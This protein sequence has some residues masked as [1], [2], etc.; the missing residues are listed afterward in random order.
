MPGKEECA[1]W[2]FSARF[3]IRSSMICSLLVSDDAKMGGLIAIS[4]LRDCCPCAGL[5]GSRETA[6]RR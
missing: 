2:V 6:R 4:T 3:A 5:I 1:P